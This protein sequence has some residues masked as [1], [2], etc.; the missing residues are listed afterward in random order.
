MLVYPMLAVR[1]WASMSA[2]EHRVAAALRPVSVL[3]LRASLAVVYN[4][5]GVSK[6]ANVTRWQHR[7]PARRRG[8]ILPGSS[9]CSAPR[10]WVG[11]RAYRIAVKIAFCSRPK[12]LSSMPGGN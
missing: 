6:V 10:G 1:R 11:A 5:F 4:W 3:A 7:S 9:H 2:R 12:I 8:S